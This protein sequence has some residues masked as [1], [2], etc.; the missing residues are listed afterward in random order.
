MLRHIYKVK[1]KNGFLAKYFFFFLLFQLNIPAI[2]KRP[3][4]L[5]DVHRVHIVPYKSYFTNGVDIHILIRINGRHRN[6]SL[7]SC[8]LWQ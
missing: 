5:K 6:K 4:I 7:I 2:K 1:S 3:M 8:I